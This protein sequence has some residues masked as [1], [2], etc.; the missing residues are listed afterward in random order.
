MPLDFL[1]SVNFLSLRI[2]KISIL[3]LII[4]SGPRSKGNIDLNYYQ[5]RPI[6]MALPHIAVGLT[7]YLACIT[8][9]SEGE[10]YIVRFKAFKHQ[11]I[12]ENKTSLC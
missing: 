1:M 6:Y 11:G 12:S 3:L 5:Y 7:N 2:D 8:L 9:K 4:K 10:P